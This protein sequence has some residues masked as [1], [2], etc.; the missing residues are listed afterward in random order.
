M[1]PV[2]TEYIPNALS[3]GSFS[4][5]RINWKEKKSDKNEEND[6]LESSYT[7]FQEVAKIIKE[8]RCDQRKEEKDDQEKASRICEYIR[9]EEK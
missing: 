2:V 7:I 9:E 3:S 6:F 8:N 1:N 4:L 5:L